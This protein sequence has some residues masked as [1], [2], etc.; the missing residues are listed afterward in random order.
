[1]KKIGNSNFSTKPTNY[2]NFFKEKQ[3][4]ITK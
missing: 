1:L 4:W 3:K 2:Y